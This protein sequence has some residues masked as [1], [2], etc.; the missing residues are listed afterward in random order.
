MVKIERDVVN[1][2]LESLR[3]CLLR[4]KEKRT[5]SLEA[6]KQD[7]DIQDIVSI[8]LERA[9]QVCVDI[10]SHVLAQSNVSVP[11]TMAECFIELKSLG[12]LS[13][14]VSINMIKAIGLRNLLVH[15]YK[16]IDWSKVYEVLHNNLDDFEKFAKEVDQFFTKIG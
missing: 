13:N 7:V 14:E 3:K 8:N 2:K 15:E 12:A 10:S 1:E 16:K 9:A 11:A 4:L 6:F 5:I